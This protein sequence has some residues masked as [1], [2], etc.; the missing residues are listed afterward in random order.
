[1]AESEMSDGNAT[2][3]EIGNLCRLADTIYQHLGFQPEDFALVGD[4]IVAARA[5][6]GNRAW[7]VPVGVGTLTIYLSKMTVDVSLDPRPLTVE[8]DAPGDT[9]V[10]SGSDI[11]VTLGPGARVTL[12]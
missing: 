5:A 2:G 7:G 11:R 1:M 10:I 3:R 6:S 9:Y 8:S 12:L 4:W